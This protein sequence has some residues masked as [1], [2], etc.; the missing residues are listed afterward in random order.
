MCGGCLAIETHTGSAGLHLESQ[1]NTPSFAS[2]GLVLA[3]RAFGL[4]HFA[5]AFRNVESRSV[6][7]ATVGVVREGRSLGGSKRRR[8]WLRDGGF[9]S[10]HICS[11]WSVCGTDQWFLAFCVLAFNVEWRSPTAPWFLRSFSWSHVSVDACRRWF[12]GQKLGRLIRSCGGQ[13]E[14]FGDFCSLTAEMSVK[15][16]LIRVPEFVIL[17]KFASDQ[18]IN[19]CPLLKELRSAILLEN[20]VIVWFFQHHSYCKECSAATLNLTGVVLGEMGENG[21]SRGWWKHCFVQ[22]DL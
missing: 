3:L 5:V 15:A 14:R 22:K 11:L 13:L 18:G 7:P 17:W 9:G 12:A 4:V 8:S 6:F 16:N 10:F 20:G 19:L 21:C 1:I 2:K